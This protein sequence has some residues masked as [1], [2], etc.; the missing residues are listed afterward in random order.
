MCFLGLLGG[1]MQLAGNIA[2]KQGVYTGKWETPRLSH[3]LILSVW[4]PTIWSDVTVK[5]LS[6]NMTMRLGIICQTIIS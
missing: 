2:T 4:L 5:V 3:H 1:K 6:Q